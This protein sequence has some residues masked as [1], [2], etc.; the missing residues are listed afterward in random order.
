VSRKFGRKIFLEGTAVLRVS[1]GVG[2]AEA[3]IAAVAVVHVD[4]QSLIEGGVPL[5]DL[6]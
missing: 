3:E 4:L 1:E 2:N 5:V 6:G